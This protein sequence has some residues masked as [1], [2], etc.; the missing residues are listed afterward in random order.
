[1]SACGRSSIPPATLAEM[2]RSGNDRVH[3]RRAFI[4]DNLTRVLHRVPQLTAL[5]WRW[6]PA[7]N[8]D[9]LWEAIAAQKSLRKLSFSMESYTWFYSVSRA[10]A[11]VSSLIHALQSCPELE[12]VTIAAPAIPWPTWDVSDPVVLSGEYGWIEYG[13]FDGF[14]L[15]ALRK[16][17]VR[18]MR[19]RVWGPESGQNL[20]WFLADHGKVES[21]RM[22][23]SHF[24]PGLLVG[25]GLTCLT[26][27]E[28][29]V[30]DYP[31]LLADIPLALQHLPNLQRLDFKDN[32]VRD[33]LVAARL[34]NLGSMCQWKDVRFSQSHAQK[35]EYWAQY[36]SGA[37]ALR[38]VVLRFDTSTELET[39]VDQQTAVTDQPRLA[40]I[41]LKDVFAV[42]VPHVAQSDT[43]VKGDETRSLE[44]WIRCFR[45]PA[46]IV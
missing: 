15:P 11:T 43:E 24:R 18:Q 16:L 29:D 4:F 5:T 12:E 25:R 9:S 31:G 27:L 41:S 44:L 28:L 45:Q 32:T 46:T 42:N 36:F 37:P 17:E 21:L 22:I 19:A 6:L 1:M 38:T 20:S 7:A 39:L 10:T 2:S 34:L 26:Y 3:S 30:E 40:G 13:I 14:K 35:L 8:D 33:V 23:Q